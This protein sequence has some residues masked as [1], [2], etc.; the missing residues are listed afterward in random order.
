MLDLNVFLSC[1]QLYLPSKTARLKRHLKHTDRINH[2]TARIRNHKKYRPN[3]WLLIEFKKRKSLKCRTICGFEKN[4]FNYYTV[5]H[6]LEKSNRITQ[7]K[8]EHS[9]FCYAE[10]K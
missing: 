2:N 7:P 3:N 1:Q 8:T 10:R 5:K 9:A 6:S 4:V